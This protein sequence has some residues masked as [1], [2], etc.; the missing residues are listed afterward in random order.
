MQ[1]LGLVVLFNTLSLIPEALVSW[2]TRGKMDEY[3]GLI[4]A[5]HPELPELREKN[6]W[7]VVDGL[8]LAIQE[9]ACPLQ[10]N[11]YYNDW[12]SGCYASSVF[13]FA[14]DGKIVWARGN[15]PGSYAF[16]RIAQP[17][18]DKLLDTCRFEDATYAIA[19]DSPFRNSGKMK[20]LVLNSTVSEWGMG[21]LQ[22]DYSIL[23]SILPNNHSKRKLILDCCVLLHNLRL[24]CPDAAAFYV[25]D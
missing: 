16:S 7:G 19:G 21:I 14:P 12:L 24:S 9:P 1:E 10:K 20:N 6:L 8:S 22:K 11:A 2:P 13:V 17:L 18:Y 25:R 3:V 4:S 15:F 23:T 5:R